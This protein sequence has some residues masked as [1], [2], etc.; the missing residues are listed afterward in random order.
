MSQWFIRFSD[1]I[2]EIE[3]KTFHT[4]D[5]AVKNNLKYYRG[6]PCKICNS[7]L[8]YTSSTRCVKCLAAKS[9]S[10]QRLVD[11]EPRMF[12]DIP[13]RNCK[14]D[15][16]IEFIKQMNKLKEVWE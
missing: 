5:V 2:K 4:K 15:N 6:S 14:I 1:E 11:K 8:K 7:C 16:D 13:T 9:N 10:Q 3:A 12:V